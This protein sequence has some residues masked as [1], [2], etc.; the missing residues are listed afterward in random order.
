M[1]AGPISGGGACLIAA[2][3]ST[4]P[5]RSHITPLLPLVLPTG[6]VEKALMVLDAVSAARSDG[7]RDA[8]GELVCF[9]GPHASPLKRP[10][11]SS[12][13][14]PTIHSKPRHVRLRVC[15]NGS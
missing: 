4:T 11:F 13:S 14:C 2:T 7:E 5:W 6:V 15:R 8:G 9:I 1:G 12:S 10:S 3:C